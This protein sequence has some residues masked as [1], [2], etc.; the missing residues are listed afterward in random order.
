MI[1]RG[2]ITGHQGE[3]C[4]KQP[5]LPPSSLGR[6][7]NEGTMGL[8]AAK[9]LLRHSTSSILFRCS[10]NSCFQITSVVSHFSSP[11][12]P[13]PLLYMP[14]SNT[15]LLTV[16]SDVQF[17]QTHAMQ[18]LAVSSDVQPSR[19]LYFNS[20]LNVSSSVW[21]WVFI[22]TGAGYCRSLPPQQKQKT[23]KMRFTISFIAALLQCMKII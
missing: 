6:S 14:Q 11:N 8:G 4:G 2:R 10:R 21:H 20:S 22:A 16:A 17:I 7:D 23:R 19:T 9:D 1:Q 15:L 18:T 12:P 13:L 3:G 5:S